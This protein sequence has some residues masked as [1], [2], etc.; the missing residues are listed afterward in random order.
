MVQPLLLPDNT[1][2]WLQLVIAAAVLVSLYFVIRQW[3]RT[4]RF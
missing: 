3:R 2:V 1:P 4:G